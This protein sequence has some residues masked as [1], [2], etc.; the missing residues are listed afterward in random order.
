VH[1]STVTVAVLNPEV[2]TSFVLDESEVEI[3]TTRG[4]GPGGQNRNKVE[5]CVVATH[6]PSGV[7]VRVDMRSQHQ[8]KTMALK[9]L[10]A[11]LSEDAGSRQEARRSKDRKRQVGSGMRGDKIRTYRTQDDQVTDHR[12]GRCWKL[13]RW[14][15]GEW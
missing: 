4:T 14:V 15:R 13:S 5:S 1:T 7:S 10:T 12:T 8:S 9:I 2:R 3:R 6:K 11:K